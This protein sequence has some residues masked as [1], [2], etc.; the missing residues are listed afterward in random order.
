[1][2]DAQASHYKNTVQ[3][4]MTVSVAVFWGGIAFGSVCAV[5]GVALLWVGTQRH[6]VAQ[7][8]RD[9]ETSNYYNDFYKPLL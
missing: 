9:Q 4:G 1:M 5:A 7:A 6:I 3:L 8:A 2:S